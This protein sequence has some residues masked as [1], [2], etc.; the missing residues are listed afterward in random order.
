MRGVRLE[1]ADLGWHGIEGDRRLAFR[2][3]GDRSG[4]PWLTASKL[5][6]LILF[7]PQRRE[8]NARD[9]LS[10]HVR[11]PEGQEM[12]IFGDDLAAELG[13]RHGTPVQITHLRHGIFDD[14][15]VSVIAFDTA[16]EIARLA[17]VI[18]DLRDFAQTSRFVCSSRFPSRKANG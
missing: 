13:R 15:S 5:P 16:H 11:T 8:G 3:I 12:P 14:A 18:S 6:E 1:A 7:T 4:F 10:T 9:E 17:G 2:R